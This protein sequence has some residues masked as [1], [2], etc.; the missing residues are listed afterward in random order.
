MFLLSDRIL[1]EILRLELKGRKQAEGPKSESAEK[2]KKARTALDELSKMGLH[3][4]IYIDKVGWFISFDCP[5]DEEL[6]PNLGSMSTFYEVIGPNDTI[7]IMITKQCS[8]EFTNKI[9]SLITFDQQANSV[10]LWKQ[11]PIYFCRKLPDDGFNSWLKERLIKPL[12]IDW[13]KEL[14]EANQKLKETSVEVSLTLISKRFIQN[15]PQTVFKGE[16]ENLEPMDVVLAEGYG[17]IYLPNKQLSFLWRLPFK[18]WT[19][20]ELSEDSLRGEPNPIVWESNLEGEAET[21]EVGLIREYDLNFL[22]CENE[23]SED[24]QISLWNKI[25]NCEIPWSLQEYGMPTLQ[26]SMCI[27]EAFF[28]QQGWAESLEW[29]ALDYSNFRENLSHNL[30]SGKRKRLV[31]LLIQSRVL[32]ISDTR[33][34]RE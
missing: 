28:R 8:D 16:E 23:I 2:A 24:L 22:G 21:F 33:L 31:L 12:Q 10:G 1:E 25:G 4:G 5:T 6:R 29:A 18:P 30:K 27:V 32:G 14:E 13:D 7:F 9:V 3:N 26:S 17:S 11:V 20:Q 34:K 19:S 15:W